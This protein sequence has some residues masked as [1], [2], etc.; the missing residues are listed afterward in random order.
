MGSSQSYLTDPS[1]WA[2][3]VEEM[4]KSGDNWKVYDYVIVGGGACS[5]F[6]IPVRLAGDHR[7]SSFPHLSLLL[8]NNTNTPVPLQ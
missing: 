4:G 6:R 1:K 5:F 3:P 8:K 2:T 7:A